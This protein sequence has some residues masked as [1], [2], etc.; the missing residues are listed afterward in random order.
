MT[1]IKYIVIALLIIC[2][3][4]FDLNAEISLRGYVKEMPS[5]M[6]DENFSYVVFSNTLHNRLNFQWVLSE[7]VVFVTEARNRFLYNELFKTYPDYK[8]ILAH[9]EG[10]VNLSFMW[11]DDG[12][13]IGQTM[14]DRVYLDWATAQW[15]IRIGRQRINWGINLISNPNDLF[16][17]YSFFDFDYPERPGTDAIRIQYFFGA[18]SR[19]QIAYKP[20]RKSKET[21][22]AAMLNLNNWDYDFQTLVGYYHERIALGLGWAGN[23]K[24]TGFKGEA[25]WFYD[26]KESNNKKKGNLVAAIGLDYIFSSGTYGVFEILYNGGYGRSEEN[27]ILITQPLRADNIMFSEYA[28]TIS[29]QHPFSS[30]WQGG[31]SIMVLPDIEAL[32]ISPSIKY[33]IIKNLDLDFVSQ[34]FTGAKSSL[35]ENTGSAYYLSVQYSF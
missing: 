12:A 31:F 13:F 20:A 8:K 23:I 1:L 35:V 32:F 28:L 19:M 27:I 18:M 33:S 24:T 15:Q 30:L 5:L 2:L 17:T 3:F 29:A 11:F 6:A 22:A 25:T 14:F 7:N 9:D 4:R 16:N 21:V 26:L 34:I 10:L